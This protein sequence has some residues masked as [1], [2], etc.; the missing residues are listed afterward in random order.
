MPEQ[1]LIFIIFAG[2]VVALILFARWSAAERRRKLEAWTAQRGWR[3][4]GQDTD[5]MEV[6]QERFSALAV[7]SSR[8]GFNIATGLWRDRQAKTFDWHW[9][10][11]SGK[12]RHTHCMT[13]ALVVSRL[14]LK[15]LLVRPEQMFDKLAELVGFNDIDFES[16]EFSRRFFVKAEDRRWAYDVIQPA[17]MEYLLSA[18]AFSLAM[19]ASGVLVW[20]ERQWEPEELERALEHASAVLDRMP[21][22]LAQQQAKEPS[23]N[24]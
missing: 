9:V 12:H 2:A 24:S 20:D 21:G 10:T 3:F 5:E 1:I 23:W 17:T 6:L 16:A 14:P 15:P 13:V 18:P 22:F 11:G 7:G 19:S 8:H 4:Q